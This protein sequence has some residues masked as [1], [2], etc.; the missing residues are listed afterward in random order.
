[1]TRRRRSAIAAVSLLACAAPLGVAQARDEQRKQDNTA[2]AV[3]EQDGG[4]AFDFAW[5]LR[6]Q[7]GD[8]V[9][10]KN[11]ANAAARCTDC[12]AT[13]IAFQI[14]LAGGSPSTVEPVNQALAINDACTR[15]VVYAG[16]RQFVRVVPEGHARFTGEGR[17]TLADVR[18]DLRALEGQDLTYDELHAAVEE[19]EARVLQV[20]TEEVVTRDGK[21]TTY[22]DK[23][24]RQADDH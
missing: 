1:M 20:L 4:K 7:R 9:D 18:N 15:C 22:R 16:A 24:D 23:R 13:S 5:S 21:H 8:V 14:V 19:Q 17:S 10:N 11:V 6:R 12:R 2:A 3:I